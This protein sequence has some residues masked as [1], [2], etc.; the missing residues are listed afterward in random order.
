MSRKGSPIISIRH[1]PIYL[2][3]EGGKR[4]KRLILAPT[5]ALLASVMI[6]TACTET[7]KRSRTEP[8]EVH[9][10]SLFPETANDDPYVKVLLNA[11]AHFNELN[12]DIKVVVDYMPAGTTMVTEQDIFKLLRSDKAPDIIGF[13]VSQVQVAG[14]ENLLFDLRRVSDKKALDI[15]ERVLDLASIDG[16]LL[17][18]PY[19][20][21]PSIVMYNKET[22]DAANLTY[23]QGEWTWEQ[24]QDI[25]E[26]INKDG[27]SLLPYDIEALD[28]LAGSA[29]QGLLSPDGETAVGYLDSPEAIKAL[30]WMNETYRKGSDDASKSRKT[31]WTS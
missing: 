4:L 23:P 21:Y 14:Q 11:V 12:S 26:K 20:A 28:L 30:R 22:F 18:L 6:M 1:K 17:A 9:F 13:P 24:F 10:Q 2:N 16:K 27:G 5:A 8:A 19:A 15:P 25:A 31:E 29:G 3:P 7:K